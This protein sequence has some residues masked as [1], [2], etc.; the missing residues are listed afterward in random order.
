MTFLPAFLLSGFIFDIGSTPVFI[1]WVTHI[2]PARYF[3]ALLQTE[4]LAGDILWVILPNLAALVLMGLILTLVVL[5]KSYKR[6]D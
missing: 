3:V 5:K 6:L 4:F 1:Q 2:V